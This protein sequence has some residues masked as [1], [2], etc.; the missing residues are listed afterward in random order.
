MQ[1]KLSIP[2]KAKRHTQYSVRLSTPIIKKI[3][4][5]SKK[6]NCPQAHIVETIIA[7]VK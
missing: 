7:A 4:A 1:L 2:S 5:L 6:H 3:K